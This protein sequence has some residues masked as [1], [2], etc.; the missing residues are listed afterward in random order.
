MSWIH[1]GP[2][3]WYVAGPLIGLMVPLLL[4]VGGRQF[5]LSANLRHMCAAVFPRKIKFLL[6]D[7]R[8]EGGWNLI[9][10]LG[11]IAGG[12]VAST[13][14]NAGAAVEI[15][16]RT[17]A[18]ATSSPAVVIPSARGKLRSRWSYSSPAISN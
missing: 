1:S 3:P 15:A 17:T 4:L 14:L 8:R 7:W 11:V 2:W 10:A 16:P 12:W 9:F 18:S 13:W 6:Y 5:G